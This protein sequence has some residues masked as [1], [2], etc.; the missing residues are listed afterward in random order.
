MMLI[1]NLTQAE[2][3]F[4][5]HMTMWGSDG[6]PIMKVKGG[7]LWKEAFGIKGAPVVYKTKKACKEAI[8]KYLAVLRDKSAGRI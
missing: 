4:M 3:D 5:G 1:K 7:W 2:S 8:E 6:F